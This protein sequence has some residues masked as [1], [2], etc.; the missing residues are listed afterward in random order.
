M[1]SLFQELADIDGLGQR[2]VMAGMGA[3]RAAVADIGGKHQ[4]R[5]ALPRLAQTRHQLPAAHAGHG[6]VHQKEIRPDA[7]DQR[8]AVRTVHRRQH[9]EVERHQHLAHQLAVIL[10]VVH[11]HDGAAGTGIAGGLEQSRRGQRRRPRHRRKH[12]PHAKAGAAA[13]LALHRDVAAERFGQ[14]PGDGEAKSEARH[15]LDM[16][17]LAPLERF[18]DARQVGLRNAASVSETVKVATWLR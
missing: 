6:D 9:H 11:H 8:Q 7:F 18:E 13:A 12:Q 17:G 4:D 2:V 15:A 5:R 16:L 10:V 14:Q 3:R 1:A